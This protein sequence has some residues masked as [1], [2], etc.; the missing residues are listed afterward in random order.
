VRYSRTSRQTPVWVTAQAL[1]ALARRPFPI[2][3]RRSRCRRP[4]GDSDRLPPP[5]KVGVPRET[6]PGERRVAIV[7]EVVRRLGGK[8]VEVVVEPGAG[9]G[10]LIPDRLF[11]GAGATL[12]DPW[13][14]DV[15]VTIGA[16]TVDTLSRLSRGQ[17]LIGFLAPLTSPDTTRA[18]AEGGVTAFAMEAIPRIS[19]AQ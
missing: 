6:A 17:V 7:P 11:E 2:R 12:G 5:M 14:A 3:P 18:L 8:G 15:V 19:R 4:C 9:A 16:Q 13:G 1:T 10:A